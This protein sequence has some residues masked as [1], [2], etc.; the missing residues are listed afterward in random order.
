MA[1]S[2]NIND[3]GMIT[4]SSKIL[5]EVFGVGDRMIRRLAEEKIVVRNSHGKY[6]FLES[7]KNYILA[8]KVSKAGQQIKSDMDD[9]LD[10][11]EEKAIHEH[12]KRQITELKLQLIKGSLHKSEDVERVISNMF[13]NFKSKM[14]AMPAKLA[15]KLE[16]KRKSEIQKIL[17]DEIT[18]ALSELSSY[19]PADYYSDEYLDVE[20][21]YIYSLGDE[22]DGEEK[23]G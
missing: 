8:L 21:D 12:V 14:E 7:V 11:D 5:S 18:G 16:G 15:K 19:N 17:L 6:L 4:V 1:E 20:D 3:L 9:T 2:K 23:R 22:S 13:A 10:L